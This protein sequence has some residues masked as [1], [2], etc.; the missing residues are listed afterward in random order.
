MT[1]HVQLL[2]MLAMIAGGVYLGF[3]FDTYRRITRCVKDNPAVKYGVEIIFWLAQTGILFYAL[4]QVNEGVLRVYIFLACLLGYSMYAVML[5]RGYQYILDKIIR[6]IVI[7]TAGIARGLYVLLIEPILWLIRL[8]YTCIKGLL[9]FIIRLLSYPA[10]LLLRG[11]KWLLP[12]TF[13]K[14]ISQ[15]YRFCSTMG[16]NYLK[17]VKKI[18]QKWR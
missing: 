2:S 5:R 1:L 17:I 18:M 14:R 6:G 4:F 11:L 9:L 15:F 12:D 13:L 10:R 8:L 7:V 3:A 16:S